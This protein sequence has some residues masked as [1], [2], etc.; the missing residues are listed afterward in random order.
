[1][2]QVLLDFAARD[3]HTALL[4]LASEC[5]KYLVR[6]RLTTPL[7]GAMKLLEHLSS[8]LKGTVQYVCYEGLLM[9]ESFRK[10]SSQFQSKRDS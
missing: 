10:I 9:G 4:W 1:M 7:G 5:A 3:A 6:T 8:L 2:V